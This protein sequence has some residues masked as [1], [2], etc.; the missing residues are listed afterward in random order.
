MP[1][2]YIIYSITFNYMYV[3]II[4]SKIVIKYAPKTVDA[5]K[6]HDKLIIFILFF[7]MK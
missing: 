1:Y 5:L 2:Y 7:N 4:K 3:I 6:I